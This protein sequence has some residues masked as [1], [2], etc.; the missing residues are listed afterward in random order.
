[1]M[2]KIA[3]VALGLGLAVQAQAYDKS[4]VNL[5]NEFWGTWAIFNA[6]QKCSE[7]YQFSKPGQFQYTSLQKRMTGKFAVMRN[8]NDANALDI[9]KLKVLTDNKKASCGAAANDMSNKDLNLTLKWVSKSTAQICTDVEGK[10]CTGLY[11][12]KQK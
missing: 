1:M 11:L 3:I 7:T 6:K 8:T 5:A 4:Q 9:L 10:Q 12:I 2:K